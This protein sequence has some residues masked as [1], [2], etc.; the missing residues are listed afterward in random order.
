MD[1]NVGDLVESDAAFSG[2][3]KL[4]SLDES[5]NTGTVA[6]FESPIRSTFR[7]TNV[8]LNDLRAAAIFDEAIVFCEDD[9][10]GI[11]RRARYESRRPN[12][13]HLILFKR[14]EPAVVPIAS[15]YVLNLPHRIGPNPLEFLEARCTDTPFFTDWR[16]PFVSSYIEQRAACRSI[17]SILSSS[18]EIEPHQIAVVRRVL[19]DETQK[20]LLA[21][22][23]GLGKTIE[24]SLIIREHVLQDDAAALVLVAVPVGLVEQWR[25]ELTNRFYL[26]D[27]LDEKIFVCTHEKFVG[28]LNLDDPTLIVID[29]AH[30]VSP[31]AWST[32]SSE[33][34]NFEEIAS[35]C[36][37]TRSCLLLSGTPLSG[38]EENFLA[39]LHLLSPQS[40]SLTASG[41]EEFLKRLSERERLGGMYQALVSSNDNDSLTD[42]VDAISTLFPDDIGLRSLIELTAPFIA[43]D[44]VEKGKERSTAIAKLRTYIGENYRLHQRMLRNRRE[45]SKIVGLFPGLSGASVQSWTV[46]DQFL[47]VDQTL[48]AFRDEFCGEETMSTIVTAK[49]FV[50]WLEAYMTSP[51]LVS[52]RAKE[53]LSQGHSELREQEVE[54]LE[55]LATCGDAEQSAK[56]KVFVDLLTRILDERKKAKIVVFC[57]NVKVADHV[58]DLMVPIIPELV[59]RHCARET[60][61][62]CSTPEIRVLVCDEG[63]ED[64]LNL[65]GGEKYVVHYGIPLS[66]ARIEQRNGRVNR[67][68]AAIYARPIAC[69]VLVPGRSGFFTHWVDVLNESVGIFDRSVASLQYVL[70][71]RIDEMWR[72]VVAEGLLPLT[73]LKEELAGPEGLLEIER[74]KVSAQE[75]LNSMN[76]EVELAVLFANSLQEA[77]DSAEVQAQKMFDWI[78]NA[79]HFGRIPG[80]VPGSFRF[81]YNSGGVRGPRTLVD[82]V[83][84]VENCVTGI[85]KESSDWKA[86][87]TALMSPDRQL[88]SHGEQVY[89]M[90]YGQPFVDTIYNLSRLDTRGKCSARIRAVQGLD[91]DEPKIFFHCCWIISDCEPGV[92][93]RDQRL[94]DER[95]VPRFAC[96]WLD[97]GGR[98]VTDDKFRG[99]LAAP[100]S[101]KGSTTTANS[102]Y[103]DVNIGHSTWSQIEAYFPQSEWGQLVRQIGEESR[104]TIVQA[105]KQEQRS[106]VSGLEIY[107]EAISVVILIGS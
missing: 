75:E 66:F 29:E 26:G 13:D 83:S 31:W 81:K 107:L 25:S 63:G 52:D 60:P 68:S 61:K 101:K 33:R 105:A 16:I 8:T 90:R 7:P 91:L 88:V 6:F 5:T 95:H 69:T 15:I 44:A 86:P 36:A 22:E 106:D 24:A 49:T 3:G 79:L 42:I 55:D 50:S 38:N 80:Q 93:P 65:H 70:Q 89:P 23:V 59:E 57:G 76:E 41:K 39:M 10:T 100:Y 19:Q 74:R 9:E 56:D 96:H 40:Y 103:R 71:D 47:S 17:S 82:V 54:L 104:A 87:V 85:D 98:V 32:K 45:D 77:D 102:Q 78:G 64:G 43:W 37:R 1:F 94:A 35:V 84:F 2:V 48:N 21:D 4:I 67:Y 12:G 18:V 46:D 99:I 28:A 73:E 92:H 58:F 14:D 11:W 53:L 20:Y 62:F 97:G 27:L 72:K 30:Q 51:M 34:K